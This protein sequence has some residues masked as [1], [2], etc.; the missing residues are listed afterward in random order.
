[1]LN[2][3]SSVV[4]Y[5]VELLI[6]YLYFSN[7]A[8]R[9]FSYFKCMAIGCLLFG[10]G[11]V[12]NLQCAN[13]STVNTT[14]TI[15]MNCV[16]ACTCFD[17]KPYLGAFYTVILVA[18]NTAFELVAITSISALS[19][20]GFFDYNYNFS[21]FIL[22]FSISKILYLSAVVMLTRIVETKKHNSPLP[23]SL[24][25]YP[26][27]TIVCLLI[28]W[29]IC[30]YPET[31]YIVQNLLAAASIVLL[32]ATVLL[33]IAYQH[34]VERDRRTFQMQGELARLEN[35]KSYYDILEQQNEDLMAYAHDAKNHLAAITSLNADPQIERYVTALSEQLTDYSR[36]CHSG[37][38]L[39]DVM[40]HRFGVEC[41]MRGIDFHY[42]VKLCNLSYVE[43]M[44]LVAILG[45]LIDN[46][47]AAADGS[48]H[49][50]VSLTTSRAN[51]YSVLVVSN[52]CD[53]PP[54]NNGTRLITSKAKQ[55]YHGYGL[56][57]VAKTLK[58]YNGDFA[59]E[60][61]NDC[62]I[63]TV[64]AMIEESAEPVAL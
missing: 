64:T 34:Q 21:L 63:F 26:L 32:L 46:A 10:T 6:S 42:D 18:V 49:K 4:V 9:K 61:D 22:E 60:Y 58:K 35:E 55:E 53:V 52:G 19:G 11:S 1:M 56:K 45:N 17:L 54:K 51:R 50:F 31:S 40:I 37:N 2:P 8:D 3:I 48:M 27:V 23:F 5:F 44:D 13:N 33:F 14:V 41:Q 36:N 47:I 57:N 12:I 7:V 29:F 59:W 20:D 24:F 38:K 16:F 28:F 43:D 62:H 30:T 39:L 15:I 25:L